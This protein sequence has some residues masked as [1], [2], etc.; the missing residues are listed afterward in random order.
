V[1]L[2]PGSGVTNADIQAFDQLW[3]TDLYKQAW[4]DIVRNT[5]CLGYDQNGNPFDNQ[6]WGIGDRMETMVHMYDLTQAPRYLDHL[7]DL[8]MVILAFRDDHMDPNNDLSPESKIGAQPPFGTRM[9]G[10]RGG[11][12]MPA[13]G[14]SSVGWAGYHS[15]EMDIASVFSYPIAAFARIVAENPALYPAYSAFAQAAAIQVLQT[16]EAFL[17]EF[18]EQNDGH[19]HIEGYFVS[20]PSG[21]TLL[22]EDACNR[23]K[24]VWGLPSYGECREN[25]RSSGAVEP[26]NRT[27]AFIKVLIELSRALDSPLFSQN[28]RVLLMARLVMPSTVATAHRYFANRLEIRG[29]GYYVWNYGP[30]EYFNARGTRKVLDDVNHGALSMSSIAL[31]WRDITRLNERLAQSGSGDW[32]ALSLNDMTMFANTFYYTIGNNVKDGIGH[33]AQDLT[34]ALPT[35]TDDGSGKSKVDST[36]GSCPGWLSLAPFD[37]SYT[38]NE[39]LYE[40]CEAVTLR[41]WDPTINDVRDGDGYPQPYLGQ[42]NHAALLTMKQFRGIVRDH[43]Q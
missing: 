37:W 3:M 1:S 36:D 10:L 16:V 43:R 14:W 27:H 4:F 33:L 2:S 11:R 13:W 42:A 26:Y 41:L 40:R 8:A 31:L 38:L 30:D 32:I 39:R 23:A 15:S 29:G 9:D 5:F 18:R 35:G 24:S 17:P 22:T 20:P 34:G 7:R 28:Q 12:V 25:Q 21:Q 6:A 19:G